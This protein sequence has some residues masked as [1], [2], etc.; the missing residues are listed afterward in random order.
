MS[1]SMSTRTLVCPGYNYRNHGNSYCIIIS[2]RWG[3]KKLRV[4]ALSQGK[5][6]EALCKRNIK[7]NVRG[8]DDFFYRYCLFLAQSNGLWLK[9]FTGPYR[10][11]SYVY[12]PREELSGRRPR[13]LVQQSASLVV[14]FCLSFADDASFVAPPEFILF[15]WFRSLHLAFSTTLSVTGASFSS[16]SAMSSLAAGEVAWVEKSL[17][18]ACKSDWSEC[19]CCRLKEVEGLTVRKA[20]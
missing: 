6:G 9:R 13:T 5:N 11:P 7:Q 16:G 20:F 19:S 12:A 18:T 10:Y 4:R 14:G 3:A 2:G 15:S 1:M 8:C 17:M